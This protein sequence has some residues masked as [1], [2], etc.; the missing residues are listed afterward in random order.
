MRATHV[1]CAVQRGT[2]DKGFW[3]I[4]GG[5]LAARGRAPGMSLKHNLNADIVVHRVKPNGTI[6]QIDDIPLLPGRPTTGASPTWFITVA[7]S[8][9]ECITKIV[10]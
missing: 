5:R 4:I 10:N 6:A 7:T 9:G 1:V 2:R 3:S 8:E